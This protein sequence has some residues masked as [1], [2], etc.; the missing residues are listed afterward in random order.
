MKRRTFLLQTSAIGAVG[1]ASATLSGRAASAP[2]GDPLIIDTD[3]GKVR[4]RDDKGT[5]AFL[6][7]P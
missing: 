2:G 6:G 4:G 5:H 1:L 7:I 3:A